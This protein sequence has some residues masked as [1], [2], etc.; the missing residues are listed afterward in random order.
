MLK[1]GKCPQC[2]SSDI[3]TRSQGIGWDIAVRVMQGNTMY[4]TTG[5]TTYLCVSCGLFENYVTDAKYRASA[6]SDP[7]PLR[8]DQTVGWTPI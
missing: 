3:V 8:F 4:P 5:W 2:G 1:N 7:E 6:K